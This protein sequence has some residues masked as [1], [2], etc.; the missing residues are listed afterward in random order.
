MAAW[1]SA[2]EEYF[3]KA[4]PGRGKRRKV[5][6]IAWVPWKSIYLRIL[7]SEPASEDTCGESIASKHAPGYFFPNS[8]HKQPEVL[9]R[10]SCV[11][12]PRTVC[13]GLWQTQI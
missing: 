12:N 13:N 11:Q 9:L 1:A 6:R 2:C 7:P 8:S 5:R 4:H 3:T 10:Q